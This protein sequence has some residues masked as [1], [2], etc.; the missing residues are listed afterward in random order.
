MYMCVEAL[1]VDLSQPELYPQVPG[2]VHQI[3]VKTCR[4]D[5]ALDDHGAFFRVVVTTGG[6]D[7]QQVSVSPLITT[8]LVQTCVRV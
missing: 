8:E 3:V 1:P 4:A 6:Q 2:G 7:M 5:E